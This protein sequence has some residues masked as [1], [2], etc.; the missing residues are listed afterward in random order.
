MIIP[1]YKQKNIVNLTSSILSSLGVK[2]QY[3]KLKGLSS[4]NLEKRE[5]I[6]LIVLDGLGYEWL[7]NRAPN[8]FMGKNLKEKL[9]SVFPS[10][11]AAAIPMFMT[12]FPAQQH[13]LTG[14]TVFFKEI[15]A[16]VNVLPSMPTMGGNT[17]SDYGAHPDEL[18]NFTSLFKNI[19]RDY[20]VVTKKGLLSS[21]FNSKVTSKSKNL[22]YSDGSVN[23]LFRKIKK[24][25]KTKGKKYVYAYWPFYDMLCH[26][27]GP[28][29]KE[30]MKHFID[31]DRKLMKFISTIDLNNTTVLLTADHGFVQTSKSK[32]IYVKDHPKLKECLTMPLCGENRVTYAYVK[33]SKTKD[34][35]KYM[36]TKLSSYCNIIKSDLAIKKNYF[37]LFKANP[38]LKDRIGDYIIIMKENYVL[39]DYLINKKSP[40]FVGQHAGVSKEEMF[41]PLVIFDE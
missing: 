3:A 15:G 11:T 6:V 8:S 41:V 25:I 34:F 7:V 19:K 4:T 20:Y 17:F 28:K 12:G 2:S 38:K 27:H 9:G 13:A 26:H 10:T 14:W 29:S 24:A 30:V 33:P 39:K 36:K 40:G 18:Y 31:F 22:V 37:G 21:D 1:N 16:M 23:H 5:N 32:E 35:E